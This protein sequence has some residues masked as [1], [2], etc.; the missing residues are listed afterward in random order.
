[1]IEEI[2]EGKGPIT[3][4]ALSSVVEAVRARPEISRSLVKSLKLKI[5][6]QETSD[7]LRALELTE[8]LVT[9]LEFSFHEHIADNEFLNSLSRVLQRAECP[10]EVKTKILRIAADWAAKFAL[11]SDLLPNF[12]AFHA[13]L[14]SEGY[15]VPQAFD[16]PISGDQQMLD[17]YLINEAEGQDPEE[18]KIEVK[19]TLALFSDIAKIEVRDV[20]QT[21]ALISIASNLERY[22]EQLQLWM[23]KLEQDDY[24]RDALSLNDE[25]VRALKQFRLMRTGNN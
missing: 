14:I 2:V 19:A 6:S 12:E 25:V 24:M 20:A 21:E 22:S 17:S 16:A 11:V 23:A 9:A 18:F 1:M 3:A 15:P 13:R 4:E 8:Q 7:Q 10:K 5:S